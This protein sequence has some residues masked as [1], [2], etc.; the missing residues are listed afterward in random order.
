MYLDQ[1]LP[2]RPD[3]AGPVSSQDNKEPTVKL[4]MQKHPTIKKRYVNVAIMENYLSSGYA[5]WVQEEI[6][7]LKFQFLNKNNENFSDYQLIR[8]KKVTNYPS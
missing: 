5:D 3:G 7:H 6:R 2:H 8:K 4:H 1:Y